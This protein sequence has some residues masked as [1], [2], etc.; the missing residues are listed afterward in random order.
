M[1]SCGSP[2]P[3]EN[4]SKD[5]VRL[6]ATNMLYEYHNAIENGGLTA[7]FQFLDHSADFFW[8]PPGYTSKLSYDSVYNILTANDKALS[9]IVLQWDTLE[10][11]PLSNEIAT[12]TGRVTGRMKD[13]AGQISRTAIIESG[14]LIKRTDGWKLLSGQSAL[15]N[16][17]D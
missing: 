3:K 1:T 4:L 15:L 2:P 12:F 9:S 11:F 13:T 7:E 8:V 17:D 10:V 16:T 14:T 5:K 6:E